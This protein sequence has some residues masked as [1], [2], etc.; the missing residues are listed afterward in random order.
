MVTFLDGNSDS[1]IA[2]DSAGAKL[3]ISGGKVG[4]GTSSAELLEQISLQLQELITWTN[5]VAAVHTHQGNLGYPTTP[6]TQA[7][8]YTNLGTQ[9]TT[10]KGKV[11]SIKGGV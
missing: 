7:T 9:L 10:I 3:K 2:E 4:L 1:I 11:D 8:G 5:T 6:P